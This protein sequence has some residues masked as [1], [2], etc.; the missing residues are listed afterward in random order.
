MSNN[1]STQKLKLTSGDEFNIMSFNILNV[2]K[3]QQ[4]EIHIN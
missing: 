1:L 2:K 4:V 3:T